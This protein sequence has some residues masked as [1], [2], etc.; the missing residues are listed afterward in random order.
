M[1]TYRPNLRVRSKLERHT[2]NDEEQALQACKLGGAELEQADVL[3]ENCAGDGGVLRQ[4]IYIDML[5]FESHV[6]V[7]EE[8]EQE[9]GEGG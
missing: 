6:H 9:G 2:V 5:V 7:V 3:V 8:E 4:R 1:R